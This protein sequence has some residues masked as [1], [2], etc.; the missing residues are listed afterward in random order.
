M[1]L[2]FDEPLYLWLAVLVIPVVWFGMRTLRGMS[3]LRR[4]VSI[5]LRVVLMLLLTGAVAGPNSVR[6]THTLAVVAV[7]DVSGSV[8]RFW[9][10]PRGGDERD[11]VER[12][13]D[14][15]TKATQRVGEED[16]VGVVVFDGRSVTVAQP[17][18]ANIFAKDWDLR[19]ADGTNIADALRLA[20]TIVPPQAGA[21]FVLFSDGNQTTGS[22][23]QAAA[24]LSGQGSGRTA[25][26]TD[27]EP[28]TL[29]ESRTSASN[30]AGS[31]AATSLTGVRAVVDV[32]P[33]SYVVKRE[34]A[35]EHVDAPPEAQSGSTIS[36][37]ALISATEPTQGYLRLYMDDAPVDLSPNDP[38]ESAKFVQL[39]EGMNGE[40]LEVQ[41]DDRR[42][43]R[44]RVVFEPLTQVGADGVP[45]AV[46]DEIV[47]NNTG[48]A[49]TLAP[50][51]G[52]ILIADGET[53]GA[54]SG[55]AATLTATLRRAGFE[56]RL[57]S[58]GGIPTDLI[59]LQ[60]LD[61]V[62]LLNASADAVALPTQTALAAYV[63]DL[64][65]GL[66]MTGG[67]DSFGAGGW[68]GSPVEAI[69]PVM[70]DLPEKLVTSEVAIVFVLDNS[71]SMWRY[72]MGSDRTQQQIA[73]DAAALAVRSLDRSDNVGVIT[74]NSRADELV[75]LAPNRDPA[76]TMNA[77]R[78][79]MSGGGTNALPAL[80]MARERLRD[81]Q[82][83]HKHIVVLTDGR[84]LDSG[85]LPKL[86]ED[87]AGEGV[88]VST[89]AVGDDAD[90]ETMEL[91][92][93]KGGGEYFP[94][95]NPTSLPQ[96]FLKAVRIVRS[97]LTRE[98][99]FV[100]LVL[101]T[102][103]AMTIG[104]PATI[105]PLLGLSLTQARNDPL[106][107]NAMTTEKGEPVLAH[108]QVG[109]G[110]CVAFTSDTSKWATN[111][112]DTPLYGQLWAQI[113][114]AASRPTAS[115]QGVQASM[116]PIDGGGDFR[117]RFTAVNPDGSSRDGLAVKASVFAPGG[118]EPVEVEL[119]PVGPGVYETTTPAPRAGSYV[120][121]IKPMEGNLSLP[122][123]VTGAAM[124]EGQEF[125]FRQSNDSLL[126]EVAKVGGGKVLDY[127]TPATADLFNREGVPT[128]E[129]VL[130]LHEVVLW[131]LMGLTLVDIASRR[132]AWDRWVSSIFAA[133]AK[134][135][136][137]R[138]GKPEAVMS[139]LKAAADRASERPQGEVSIALGE[140]EAK[141]IAEEAR[142]RRRAARLA[143]QA[144]T[145]AT[146][147]SVS[148]N[149]SDLRDTRE[150][151]A[152]PQATQA[153]AVVD[154][155]TKA[156]SKPTSDQ[157]AEDAKSAKQEGSSLLAAKR[158]AARKFEDS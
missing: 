75:Q 154:L 150:L 142:D 68:R 79:I 156:D 95:T 98:E 37:R 72:V 54:E 86:C 134:F 33:L 151:Q 52:T 29:G 115:G 53:E 109:L 141:R 42:V 120:A 137:G 67:R 80:R 82:A 50:G 99:P 27:G 135:T 103:S 107:V 58:A 66:V 77:V 71:G 14:Y 83:K 38:R 130:P 20:R 4:W 92:A 132:V 49:F 59:A 15:L 102:G 7:V 69:L 23:A 110:Q 65:G 143:Q 26:G 24:E 40:R 111:W 153:A 84:S 117:L 129:S 43:H 114:R 122:P 133:S 5:G 30:T 17:T 32:V 48:E 70:L 108:W 46:A 157:A 12:I 128:R 62:V 89:I 94:V 127:S 60:E 125:R 3:P 139:T 118:S 155:T 64:G 25:L 36:V 56:V 140:I 148:A 16:L 124:N 149:L 18:R 116:S 105:P 87:I 131:V 74:F 10:S 61:L 88:K 41:L 57:T 81:I 90:R 147:D 136:A 144:P 145:N 31:K 55:A 106:V 22:A 126:R 101:P 9:R 152:S 78:G 146:K 35:V 63:Q 96:I 51:K 45:I 73:N 1:F 123:V 44:F 121:I 6:T 8:R 21:R 13:K 93:R 19:V 91:M 138:E 28:E 104:L 158:R 11:A 100:P 85:D 119:T 97:P 76:K 113:V 34:V 112:I 39:A 2:R 47:E